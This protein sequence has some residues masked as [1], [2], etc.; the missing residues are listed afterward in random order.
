MR[1]LSTRREEGTLIP[2]YCVRVRRIAFLLCSVL[3]VGSLTACSGGG[4]YCDAI[5][6]N[7]DVFA[8]FDKRTQA[9]FEAN[10]AAAASVAKVAPA[11]I[12]PQWN[13]ISKATTDVV[14]ALDKSGIKLEELKLE[15]QANALSQADID[16]L[17]KAFGAFNDTQ[18][19]RE[20]VVA[21]AQ[22]E[23]G[24]DLSKK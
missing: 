22:E 17:D 10:A 12:A 6:E 13:S 15:E 21:H 24:I 7:A 1:T 20:K 23:C 8:K 9:N 14:S 16:R 19:D 4:A 3:A 5:N 18:A 2:Q 11:A